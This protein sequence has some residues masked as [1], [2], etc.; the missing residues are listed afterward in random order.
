MT[1][2]T[3][4]GEDR[5]GYCFSVGASC[6][7]TRGASWTKSLLE[8]IHGR[9]YVRYLKTQV[10]GGAIKVG[11]CP[12]SFAEHAV[13]YS[14]HPEQLR[15]TIFNHCKSADERREFAGPEPIARLIERLGPDRL[16]LFRSM[17]PP[18]LATESLGW[19][20]LRVVVPGLQPLHGHHAYAHLGGPL[21]SPRG[22]AD[23]RTMLPHPFP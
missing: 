16:V 8:A 13:Y 4:E 21:W 23:W 6:R 10:D 3:L 2:V 17:T 18:A 7:E 12:T 22:L 5:E 15:A 1:L 19:H 14:V 9:H 11:H 20:V